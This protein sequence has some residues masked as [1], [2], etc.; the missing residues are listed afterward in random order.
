MNVACDLG[1]ANFRASVSGGEG[2]FSEPSVVARDT[3]GKVT[4]GH[5]AHAMIGRNPGQIEVVSPFEGGILRNFEAAAEIIRY[6]TTRLMPRRFRRNKFALTLSIPSGLTQVELRAMEDAGK[7]AGAGKVQFVNSCVAA[8][9]GAGLPVE[10]PRGFLVV[11]LGGG[12]TEV[13]LLSLRGVVASAAVRTGG[14]GINERLSE[15]VRKEHSLLVG[16]QTM[17]TAK[18]NLCDDA[19]ATEQE[20]RGRNVLTGLPQSVMLQRTIVDEQVQSYC[21]MIVE[22]IGQVI[23]K[24]PPELAGD[25]IDQGIMLVGGGAY[26]AGIVS[27]LAAHL[28]APVIVADEPETCVIRGL[29]QYA[30][31]GPKSRV[32][33]LLEF[34]PH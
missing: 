15:Y 28:D 20:I 27:E 7:A 19:E 12:V 16:T 29:T 10:S 9:V 33:S 6:C 31:A 18:I 2:A 24:C 21:K 1:T 17:E 22:L 25:I 4:V 11:N 3:L 23:S 8:A 5:D 26:I 30:A 13:A 34:A 32:R 14:R